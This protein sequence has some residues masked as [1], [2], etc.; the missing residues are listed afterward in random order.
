MAFANVKDVLH[1][2][3]TVQTQV[4]LAAVMLPGGG[5]AFAAAQKPR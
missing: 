1:F 4:F 5:A 2:R 3:I